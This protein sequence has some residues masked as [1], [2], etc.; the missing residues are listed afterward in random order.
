MDSVTVRKRR[1]AAKYLELRVATEVGLFLAS[2]PLLRLAPKGNRRV[3]I[4]PGFIATDNSTIPLRA[5]LRRLGH[6]PTG[7][8]RGR[9]IGPVPGTVDDLAKLLERE[10]DKAGERIPIVGWSLGGI[11]ARVMAQEHPDLVDQVITLGSPFNIHPQEYTSVN[12]IWDIL[13]DRHGFERD[14]ESLDVDTIPVPSTA[15]YTRSDGVVAWQGCL[16]SECPVS[17]NIEVYGSHCGLGT[18]VAVAYLIA[19]RLRNRHDSWSPFRAPRSLR[20]LFPDR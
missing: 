15:V 17:E 13:D 2:T 20:A 5:L 19:D 9:N 18:N 3:L 12:F 8:G 14:R 4:L 6:V 7:W 11:Y 16:Q 10:A 1:P